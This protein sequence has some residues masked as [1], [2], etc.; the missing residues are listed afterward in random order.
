MLMA[1][2]DYFEEHLRMTNLT[3]QQTMSSKV[4]SEADEK[5]IGF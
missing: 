3:K 4:M 1:K 2:A 5:K